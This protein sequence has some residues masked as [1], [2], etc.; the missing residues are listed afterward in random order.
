MTISEQTSPRIIRKKE[1]ILLTGLSQASI[2]RLM[3]SNDFPKQIQITCK[4]VGW[5]ESDII[6]WI[7]ST[8]EKSR[9]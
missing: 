2:Y 3:A 5:I 6:S 8:I 7:E 4:S 9:S 1:V